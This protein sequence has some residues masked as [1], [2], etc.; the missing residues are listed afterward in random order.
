MEGR[1]RRRGRGRGRGRGRRRERRGEPGLLLL[2]LSGDREE[3][4]SL[5]G[6]MLLAGAASSS[7][8]C[9]CCCQWRVVP[10]SWDH[11]G[12]SVADRSI[13]RYFVRPG[14]LLL[15][16]KDHLIYFKQIDRAWR[17][18]QK[19]MVIYFSTDFSAPV[20]CTDKMQKYSSLEITLMWLYPGLSSLNI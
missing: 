15:I 10:S 18:S 20:E 9:G 5:E 1:G 3:G 13:K 7:P 8:R 16:S 17:R 6:G 2:L 19:V 14:V 12:T 11:H 4:A